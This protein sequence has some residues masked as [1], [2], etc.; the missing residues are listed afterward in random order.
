[1]I[2]SDL[3][4]GKEMSTMLLQCLPKKV[5]PLAFMRRKATAASA[6]SCIHDHEHASPLPVQMPSARQSTPAAGN[7]ADPWQGLTV[8]AAGAERKE[9]GSCEA[10]PLGSEL[11][12]QE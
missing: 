8:R 10:Q 4:R 7:R 12:Q 6:A 2:E 1:M 5:S 9:P 3:G 11:L